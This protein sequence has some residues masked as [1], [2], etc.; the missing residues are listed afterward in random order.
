MSK[1]ETPISAETVTASGGET[2]PPWLDAE[3]QGVWRVY[4]R[5]HAEL[6]AELHRRL[7]AQSDLSLPDYEVLV[8]LTESP[9]G[10]SARI[11]ELSRNL[12]WEK[13]RLSHH[14]KRMESRGLVERQVCATDARG[15]VVL[16]T[17][18]GRAAME[19][20]APSHV[21][22]VRRLV[23]DVLTQEQLSVLGQAS[24]RILAAVEAS[25]AADASVDRQSGELSTVT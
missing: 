22:D 3:E 11:F 23:F 4:L 7:H 6:V 12:Q 13:S 5:A 18:H 17:D 19:R 25:P 8:R 2:A 24:Q 14:L 15:A 9:S 10:G 21:R 1:S 16:V 20:A